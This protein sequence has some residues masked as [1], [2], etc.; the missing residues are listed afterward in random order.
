M[1]YIILGRC[2]FLRVSSPVFRLF[3]MISKRKTPAGRV[4]M[5]KR[6]A[7]LG[8]DFSKRRW[9]SAIFSGFHGRGIFHQTIYHVV[10][11]HRLC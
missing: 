3:K 7:A 9:E 2:L 5:W 11:T 6:L 1:R 8:P 4:E 10:S